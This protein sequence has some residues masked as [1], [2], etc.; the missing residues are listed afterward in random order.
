MIIKNGKLV[1]EAHKEIIE[2]INNIQQKAQKKIGA[3]YKGTQLIWV[4]IYNAI[5]SCFGSGIWLQD[6]L[7]I[8]DDSWKSNN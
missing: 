6:K 4:T 5:R 8:G 3:I 1:L 2:N 7:W